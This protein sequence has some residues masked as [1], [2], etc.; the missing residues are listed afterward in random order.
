MKFYQTKAWLN[1]KHHRGYSNWNAFFMNILWIIIL[2]ISFM[3]IYSNISKNEKGA[4][5][6]S[7]FILMV[8]IQKDYFIFRRII[9]IG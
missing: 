2:S 8:N 7:L 6:E 4:K 1:T 3:I 5:T 9:R